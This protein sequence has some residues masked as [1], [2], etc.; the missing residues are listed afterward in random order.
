MHV[1][2]NFLKGVIT[3]YGIPIKE[4][5][6]IVCGEADGIDTCGRK[7]AERLG[8]PVKSFPYR[9]DLGKAGGPV[10]NKAMADYA[11]GLL[12]LWNNFSKG[13]SNMLSEANFREL[14]VW[15]VVLRN[16]PAKRDL[17]AKGWIKDNK[18]QGDTK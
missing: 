7:F 17:K 9:S 3:H 6:E 14:P 13:S 8:I 16:K 15:E 2:F 18:P 1:S 10:R 11:D 4:V 5:T 12:L